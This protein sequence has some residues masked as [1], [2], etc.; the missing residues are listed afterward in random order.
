MYIGYLVKYA[1]YSR[2]S[3]QNLFKC[4]ILANGKEVQYLMGDQQLSHKNEYQND[5]K[6]N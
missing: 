3:I 2:V 4:F 1:L 5:V 6:Q